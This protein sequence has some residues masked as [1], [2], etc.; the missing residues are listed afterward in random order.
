MRIRRHKEYTVIE[1]SNEF[2]IH[3]WPP[4]ILRKTGEETD[5]LVKGEL[6]CSVRDPFTSQPGTEAQ[7]HRWEFSLKARRDE[8]GEMIPLQFI[9]RDQHGSYST[10]FRA[11]IWEYVRKVF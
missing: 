5:Y 8:T 2:V 9:N 3:Y 11:L 4:V 10:F 7:L 1:F 6:T